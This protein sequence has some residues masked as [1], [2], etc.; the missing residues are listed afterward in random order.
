MPW[1]RRAV[2]YQIYPLSFQDSNGDGKGNLVGILSRVDYLESLGID[3][4]WLGPI[5]PSPMADFGYDIAEFTG[6][7]PLFG[8]LDELGQLIAALHARSVRLILDFVPNHTSHLHPWFLQSRSSRKDPKRDWYVWADPAPGGGPPNNWLS[9]FGGPAW[10][11]DSATGQYYYHAFLKEQP[12]LNW[13]TPQVRDAMANVLRFW[14][15]RGVD[16]FRIDAAGVLGEDLRLSDEPPNPEFDE[17]MPPTERFKRICTDSQAEVLDWLAELRAVIDEFPDRVLLG[18]VDT[19]PEQ[20][21]QFYGES[22]RP[23]IHLPLN[24][25][26]L[27]TTWC[28]RE[29]AAM[30]DDY[31][32][33]IPEHGWPDWVIGSHDK[34]RIARVIGSDQTRIAAVLFLTLPGTAIFYAGDELGMRGGSTHPQQVLDPFERLV[35]GHGLNRDPERSTMQWSPEINAG[36]TNGAPWL[37]VA[38]DYAEHNVEVESRDEDSILNLYRRLIA[39]RQSN[40]ALWMGGYTALPVTGSV[41]GFIRNHARKRILVLLNFGADSEIFTFPGASG[42]RVLV[43]TQLNREK[44]IASDHISLQ[45]N[46]GLVIELESAATTLTEQSPKEEDSACSNTFMPAETTA[47]KATRHVHTTGAADDGA[48]QKSTRCKAKRLSRK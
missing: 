30:I 5:Y 27:D 12:D 24:Y 2:I 18:E 20:V 26:L 11:W 45:N 28:A 25:R 31:L 15:N 48:D 6:V 16:G 44:S 3:A 33:S 39:L 9:R 19:S 34:P 13:R 41:M 37:P 21:A 14:L 4:V 29:I 17:D 32:S 43:S 7:D 42:G 1:W 22:N 23:I 38:R 40:A 35:P 10:E 46:E 47:R 36:F 8:S